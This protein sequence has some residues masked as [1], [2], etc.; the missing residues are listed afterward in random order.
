M[1]AIPILFTILL[2]IFSAVLIF[3]F[4]SVLLGGTVKAGLGVV[5]ETFDF[6]KYEFVP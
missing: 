1:F 3:M 5:F 6:E 4:L 2:I